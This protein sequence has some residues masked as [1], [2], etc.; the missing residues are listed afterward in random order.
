MNSRKSTGPSRILGSK[1]GSKAWLA[2]LLC[3][4]A[5]GS[6]C[7][8]LL[9]KAQK[10]L[11]DVAN[12]SLPFVGGSD[13]NIAPITLAR[14]QLSTLS[15][16]D[17]LDL[18]GD[19]TH[20]MGSFCTSK[21]GSGGST[22]PTT[23]TCNI[24]FIRTDGSSG[25]FDVDTI[26]HESDLLRCQY[27][28]VPSGVDFITV[29]IKLTNIDA[30]SN[31]INFR[32][33]NATSIDPTDP[34]S[35][36]QVQRYQ[37]RDL[38]F[39][40]YLWDGSIY[41][42][43]LSEDPRF[44]FPL[45]FYTTNMGKT[46]SIYAA[47]DDSLGVQGGT[48]FFNCPPIPNDTSFGMD[49][50]IY[51]VSADTTGSKLIFPPTGLFDRST[52]F[53]A[54]KPSGV[55]NV[56]VNSVIMPGKITANAV[57]APGQTPPAVI[58]SIGF[59]ARPVIS[60]SGVESCPDTSTSIPPG[61]HWAKLWQFRAS[62]GNRLV[63]TSRTLA[64]LGQIN[65]NT[66]A[67]TVAPVP[68]APNN[69][70]FPDCEGQPSADAVGAWL[71]ARFSEGLSMCANISPGGTTNPNATSTTCQQYSST[72][73]AAGCDAHP[74]G[75]P[76]SS[77]DFST[78]APGTD[79]WVP[80]RRDPNFGCNGATPQDL[81]HICQES[82]GHVPFDSPLT[83]ATLPIDAPGSTRPSDFLFVVSPPNVTLDDMNPTSAGITH[84]IYSPIRFFSPNDCRS[85][86]PDQPLSPND[87]SP[88][89]IVHYNLNTHDVGSGGDPAAA[90]PNRSGDFPL[91]VIQP[92]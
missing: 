26:Y 77:V 88:A 8:N 42:P 48:T 44:T 51:S 59:A 78:F 10:L 68:P 5:F 75:L 58:P 64:S 63:P 89:R 7:T 55:F 57:V 52:F 29:S 12:G 20:S 53:L 69:Y 47:G 79:I 46:L 23:C 90:D 24:R 3:L 82:T 76:F 33:G 81:A 28:L 65:C 84:A 72:G 45:N 92:N 73:N 18:L 86:D 11:D 13:Q 38:I 35:F 37:C 39:I 36:V 21:S 40:P 27:T 16:T 43:I 14:V 49:L 19:G 56:P 61:F 1:A 80:T 91:C 6:G 41:D 34:A 50:S 17:T 83:V 31:S 67:Y 4:L 30:T 66:S 9:S 32:F 87:C 62:L 25:E 71:A 85:P 2:A 54:K 15:P 60:S 74:S 70:P 22:G